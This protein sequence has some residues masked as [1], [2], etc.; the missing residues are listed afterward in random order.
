MANRY[1]R[2]K[3]RSK[4]G[5]V[6]SVPERTDFL[7]LGLLRLHLR[8][9]RRL[10][11]GDGHQRGTG[12]LF[13]HLLAIQLH[14]ASILFLLLLGV[15]STLL[16]FAGRLSDAKFVQIVLEPVVHIV[17]AKYQRMILGRQIDRLAAS[18]DL[19]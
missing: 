2:F 14:H 6:R 18:D 10:N 16:L 15:A 1:W 13:E 9:R 19:V 17:G 12:R 11:T 4:T 7:G 3:I 8:F 5:A